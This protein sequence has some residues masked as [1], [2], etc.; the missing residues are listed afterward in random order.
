MRA[1]GTNAFSSHINT[2]Q[3]AETAENS[4][5]TG[6]AEPAEKKS[7]PLYLAGIAGGYFF[8][9]GKYSEYL[10]PDWSGTLF[11]QYSP[12][13]AR[14]GV[15]FE[16]TYSYLKDKDNDGGIRYMAALP[17]VLLTW[18]V[19]DVVDVQAK[20][21]I[22]VTVPIASIDNDTTIEREIS[23]AFTLGGGPA[24]IKTF[25]G[26]YSVGIDACY[27]YIFERK[28]VYAYRAGLFAGYRF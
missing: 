20:A 10:V 13:S 4:G 19:Y 9:G 23:V 1:L 26:R 28:P 17:Y 21:G 18:S 16:G 27:Y 22:G 15:G 2:R 25:A 11:F 5:R 3:P 24:I 7:G 8:S 12:R 14:G 6:T